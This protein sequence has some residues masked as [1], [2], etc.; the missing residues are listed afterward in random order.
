MSTAGAGDLRRTC[1]HLGAKDRAALDVLKDKLDIEN[2]S[3]LVRLA[4]RRWAKA[5]ETDQAILD[6][7][8]PVPGQPG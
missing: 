2:S 4:L 6:A 7:D 8:R 3:L 1:F 5:L